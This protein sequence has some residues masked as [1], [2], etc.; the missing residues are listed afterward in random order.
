M[1]EKIL[2]A[3]FNH[4][5]L[6]FIKGAE[7]ELDADFVK[8]A[9]ACC[10]RIGQDLEQEI[11]NLDAIGKASNLKVEFSIPDEMGLQV[12]VLKA[13]CSNFA[14]AQKLATLIKTIGYFPW[15]DWEGGALE[16]F[17]RSATTWSF[18]KTD[19][20][21]SIVLILSWPGHALSKV[22]GILRP[23]PADWR[24]SS[25]NTILWPSYYLLRPARMLAERIGLKTKDRS[26]YGP[27]LAT[28]ESLLDPLFEYA[29]L[30][31]NDVVAD[32]GCGDARILIAAC[33]QHACRGIG[34][35]KDKRVFDL[36]VER[37]RLEGLE[38]RVML[39]HGDG[40]GLDLSEVTVLFLFLPVESLAGILPD[41]KS[42]LPE[43]ARIIAHEQ[44]R[45]SELLP[46]E[47]QPNDSQVLVGRDAISVGHKWL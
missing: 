42:R 11:E 18:A 13:H 33:K 34:I 20:E 21:R 3:T 39:V 41:L 43:G 7:N 25:L 37:V 26:E 14:D 36:A 5:L 27:F 12:H 45:I 28:P 16:S 23:S 32:L 44:H 4:G 47:L 22:P 9:Q 19:E 30:G 10:K 40:V 15:E 46:T 31:P 24:S 29:T 6:E 1:R 17:K 2:E 38:D 35:E 8:S